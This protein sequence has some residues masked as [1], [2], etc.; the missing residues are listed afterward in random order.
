[1]DK[2]AKAL[3]GFLTGTIMLVSAGAGYL[4]SQRD[5][6]IEKIAATA[7]EYAT[8]ALG[9]KIEIGS[10]KVGNLNAGSTSDIT[11]SNLAIYDK[12][13]DLIAKAES[14][15][16]NFHLLA[17]ASDPL[18]AIDEIKVHGVEGNIVKR[19][20]DTWNF[21]DIK[22]SSEGES[23]F[24]AN[25]LVDDVKV[26]AVFDE[27]ELNAT[28]PNLNLDFDT[29]ADFAAE[30][31]KAQVSGNISGNDFDT[32]D[33]TGKLDFDH[34]NIK[35]EVNVDSLLADVNDN[36]A[37]VEKIIA[38]LDLDESSNVNT[39][40]KA[41][42]FGSNIH[43]MANAIDNKQI[44]NVDADTLNITDIL[45][46]IP[47]DTIPDGV[48]L[49]GGA[50]ND[51]K[52]NVLKRGDNLSFSG[53][54][55]VKDGSVMVEQ[56][57]IDDINGSITFTDAEIL[58]NANAQANGQYAE[59]TGSIRIDTDE[60][61]FDLNASSDS[62]NPN[63]VM[64]LPAEGTA[65]FTAHLTGTSS[66]P[67]VEADIYSP[68]I[69][70]DNLSASNV[71]THLKY[72]DNAVFLTNLK[73][74]TFG[75]TINGDL[76]LMAMDLSYNAHVMINGVDISQFKDFAPQLAETEGLFFGDVGIN[77]VGSDVDK[78][79]VYGS[80]YIANA[81]YDKLD[82]NRADT[83]FF[84]D[85]DDIKID[86]LSAALPNG[87]SLGAEGTITDGRKLDLKFYAAHI[88]LATVET[89]IP[90][91]EIS[92]LADFKGSVHGDSD[93]PNVDLKFSAVDRSE[94]IDEKFKGVLFDQPYDS[95]KFIASGSL[96]GVAIND[97]TMT[98]NGKDIWLAKG[99][100][101]LTGEKKI[102][103]QV[104]TVGARA[105][106]IIRLVAPDQA[107]T[108]NVDN[109][110]TVTGTLDKPNVVGYIHF[111]RGSYRGM[112]VNSM[113]GDYF[114][115]GTQIR[116]QDFHINSPMV[117]MDLNGTIDSASTDMNFTV[118]V[119]DINVERFQGKL[120]ENYPAH[121]H[122]KFTGII[123]GNLDHPIFDGKLNADSLSFNEVEIS[124]VNGHITLNGNDILLDNFSFNQGEG[125]Y[126]VHGRVNYL[127]NSMSGRSEVKNA[128]IPN[129]LALANLKNE[130]ITGTLNSN[131]QFGGTMQNPSLQMIGTIPQGTIA[132]CDIHD[133]NLNVTL[134]NNTIY[135]NTLEGFQGETGTI[136]ASGSAQLNGSLD[137]K[138]SAENLALEMFSKA[139]GLDAEVVG[140]VNIDAVVGGTTDNPTAQVDMSATGGLKGSTFDLMHGTFNLKDGIID[141]QELMAQRAI[142]EKIYKVSAKGLIPLVSL[143]TDKNKL[144]NS[145]EQINL[146]ISLD[147][148]DLSLLPLLS[149]DY[150]AWGIGEMAG[151]LK[152]TGTAS[153]PLINGN[154]LVKDGT[155]KIKGMSSL[156]EHMNMNLA[157]TGKEMTV[158][159]FSGN[160]GSGTYNL[161]GGLKIDGIDLADY[162][163]DLKA[164]NLGIKSNF[165]EGP[166]NAEFAL[167]QH[168]LRNPEG[169]LRAVLPKISGHVDLDKC[170]ISIPSLPESEGELPPILLDIAVNLGDKVHFYSPY[171]FDIYLTGGAK[172]EG[173]TNHPK[174]SGIITAKRGGTVNYL[175]TVFN[176]REGE[177]QFNQID[178]F[179]PTITFFAETKITK[180]KVFLSVGG[181]LNDRSIKLTSAPE[182]SETEIMQLLTLRDAYQ[183]GGDNDIETG[184][185]LMLGLQMSFLS[186]VESAVRKTIGFDQ[187][188][189]SRGSGSAFDNKS[190]LRD[191]HEE[192]YNVTMG[193]YITDNTMLKYT[194]GIGGD[195]INRYGLQYDFNDN[196]SAT[197]EKEGHASIFG[198]EAR[199]KF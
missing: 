62:F 167:N 16:V 77:G 23:K 3:T 10:I 14:A 190:E 192:E 40:I 134:L 39:D 172:F 180:T 145:A 154:I 185:L 139:A 84:V 72:Q 157:F 108:G 67:I 2:V 90:Q 4:Y 161:T 80:A 5:A 20:D 129:L 137:I 179:F 37:H 152:V 138:L 178:T 28:V 156:I 187:F 115:D 126:T 19:S 153:N 169:E 82:V 15:E 73:A 35:A 64:Y 58:L 170:T 25:I 113:D 38:A 128:D 186:E 21:E 195:N 55:N 117:D 63:A 86:Y 34:S 198:F 175:K 191:R 6:V 166:L 42:T 33:I 50:V 193:K 160:I 29:T 165:F 17:M 132:G 57:Q 189:I 99:T 95:I 140:L 31:N 106:D 51:V 151:N 103:L 43:L 18:A 118:E 45:P 60:P 65:A 52:L 174:P 78:L 188:S 89:F 26:N 30:V 121:G 91:V 101:G 54:T 49:L 56:T 150:I 96:D 85:G 79:K 8:K 53:S 94:E 68:Y 1:M 184:D 133:I 70:Y 144:L 69:I 182:M 83:S 141:V 123:G 44:I 173:S 155:T 59:V 119:Y 196:I 107:L 146:D 136:N 111:W 176:V 93:N 124:D 125:S 47:S 46:F 48:E 13:E 81:R 158:E 61:Y 75:G 181:S 22:T 148:A 27:N 199:W 92:G 41:Q 11:V 120:P 183:K 105:E 36:K 149:E 97:F 100:V 162:S 194:R 127:T 102:N 116:L 9:T 24:D 130:I 142:N 12:N 7:S 98:K 114:V 171:L 163:F 71:S 197:A 110:I 135:L 66:N 88:D 122:G 32:G 168:E 76:E 131:M 112:L 177:L 74:N 104:D 109:I 143:S 159:D 87:G 147:N 164:D